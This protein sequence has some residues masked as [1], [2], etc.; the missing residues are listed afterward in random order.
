MDFQQAQQ[1][2]QQQQFNAYNQAFQQQQDL[3]FLNQNGAAMAAAQPVQAGQQQL[4]PKTSMGQLNHRASFNSI[5]SA[6]AAQAA[7]QMQQQVS[8]SAYQYQNQSQSR[9]QS[10]HTLNHDAMNGAAYAPSSPGASSFMTMSE[11]RLSRD[12]NMEGYDDPRALEY[13]ENVGA[14]RPSQPLTAKDPGSR[15]SQTFNLRRGSTASSIM[16]PLRRPQNLAPQIFT[17]A[18]MSALSVD[19]RRAQAAMQQAQQQQAVQR[20]YP[21]P[22]PNAPE[23]TAGFPYAFP[24][25][26][27]GDGSSSAGMTPQTATFGTSTGMLTPS[28]QHQ[29]LSALMQDASPYSRSP[30]LRVSHKLAERKRR[31]EMKDLFDDLRDKLP[32]DRT[33]KTSKWEILSKAVEHVN[34]LEEQLMLARREIDEMRRGGSSGSAGGV[35]NPPGSNGSGTMHSMAM[36]S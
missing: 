31:K 12:S 32:L 3:P 28:L 29:Q 15:L 34:F 30:E 7:A 16:D 35:S 18:N 13:F 5:N 8:P 23:P 4:Q 2:Q 24:D 22:H 27:M 21:H 25:P 1:T 36:Q 17:Q 26:D 19:T 9:P 11:R 14:G 33:L 6:A 10:I 20:G